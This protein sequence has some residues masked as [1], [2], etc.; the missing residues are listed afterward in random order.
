MA[1]NVGGSL[2]GFGFYFPSGVRNSIISAGRSRIL[3]RLMYD[4]YD[5]LVEPYKIECYVQK[6]D[7]KGSEYFWGWD[8]TGGK[9]RKVGIKQFICDKIQSVRPTS[10]TF[11]PRFAVEL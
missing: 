11:S 5:R 7:G 10:E 1:L 3:I 2:G 6:S 8:L 9:S 4:G